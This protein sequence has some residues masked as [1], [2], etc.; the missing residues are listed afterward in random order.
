MSNQR[1]LNALVSL[2]LSQRDAKVYIYLATKGPQEAK[3]IAETMNLQENR[4]SRILEDLKNKKIVT[5]KLQQSE[6]FFALPFY[7][8]LDVLLKTYMKETQTIEQN[9]DEI[10]L[11]C[12]FDKRLN[13]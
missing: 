10:V 2:G 9:K 3:K 11:K 12:V 1:L 7:E 4:L 13:W 6:L 5:F 8:A